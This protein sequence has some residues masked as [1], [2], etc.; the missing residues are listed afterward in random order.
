MKVILKFLSVG[1]ILLISICCSSTE[2]RYNYIDKKIVDSVTGVFQEFRYRDSAGFLVLDGIMKEYSKDSVLQA[3]VPYVLGKKNG[4]AK[5]YY[6]N[7]RISTVKYYKMGKETEYEIRYNKDG[8]LEYYLSIDEDEN[9][10]FLIHY[11]K[12]HNRIDRMEGKFFYLMYSSPDSSDNINYYIHSAYPPKT[13]ITFEL[14][15]NDTFYQQH[16]VARRD[17]GEYVKHLAFKFDRKSDIAIVG[18]LYDSSSNQII[19]VDTISK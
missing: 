8:S 2:G 6:H 10:R 18:R 5:F 4:V 1:Y 15:R 3:E 13:T 11:K 16:K 12:G 19:K 17:M 9:T 7:K 14:F